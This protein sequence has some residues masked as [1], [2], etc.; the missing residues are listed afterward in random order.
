[1]YISRN[2]HRGSIYGKIIGTCSTVELRTKSWK[3]S[4]LLSD[5]RSFRI[6]SKNILEPSIEG[7]TSVPKDIDRHNRPRNHFT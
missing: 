4:E 1:M 5:S 6:Y 3:L 2:K 7:L